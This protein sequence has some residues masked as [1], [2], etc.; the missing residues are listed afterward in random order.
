MR[1]SDWSSDVCSS[2]LCRIKSVIAGDQRH[3]RR[4]GNPHE[5]RQLSA[6]RSLSVHDSAEPDRAGADLSKLRKDCSRVLFFL[7][8]RHHYQQQVSAIVQ[9][10]RE[11][12]DAATLL[13]PKIS[14]DP[15][16]VGKGRSVYKRVK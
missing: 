16:R 7:Q 6:I 12:K 2:D 15:K 3:A 13:S 5:P 8:R 4:R 11:K 1:I 10:I 9:Q 14:E